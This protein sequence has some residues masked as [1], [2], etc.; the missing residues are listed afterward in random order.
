M[1]VWVLPSGAASVVSVSAVEHPT[2]FLEIR[3]VACY[4][5]TV[6]GKSLRHGEE[7]AVMGRDDN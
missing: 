3:D 4:C 1:W 7:E 6:L 2:S 5:T